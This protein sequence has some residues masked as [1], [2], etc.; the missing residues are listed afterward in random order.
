MEQNIMWCGLL[1]E[2]ESERNPSVQKPTILDKIMAARHNCRDAF[3]CIVLILLDL[4][5]CC[6]IMKL[7]PLTIGPYT[8]AVPLI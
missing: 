1:W 6:Q 2:E 3:I 8:A 5:E 4:L 7:P